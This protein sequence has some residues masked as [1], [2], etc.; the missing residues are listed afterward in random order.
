MA[1]IEELNHTIAD[2]DKELTR[3]SKIQIDMNQEHKVWKKKVDDTETEFTYI[4]FSYQE[5][6]ALNLKLKKEI[7][8]GKRRYDTLAV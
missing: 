7:D 4:Q 8:E 3:C 6:S 1:K 5:T 2:K